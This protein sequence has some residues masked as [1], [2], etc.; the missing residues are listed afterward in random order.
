MCNNNNENS[1][2]FNKTFDPLNCSTLEQTECIYSWAHL[3]VFSPKY[4]NSSGNRASF[5]LNDFSYNS[6]GINHFNSIFESDSKPETIYNETLLND[7]NSLDGK[8][9]HPD[10]TSKK[11][12]NNKSNISTDFFSP[13]YITSPRWASET[14]LSIQS[15]KFS[16]PLT[17]SLDDFHYASYPTTSSVFKLDCLSDVTTKSIEASQQWNP[18]KICFF[19]KKK[20]KSKNMRVFFQ[21]IQYILFLL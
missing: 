10:Q 14:S 12:Y 5:N 11:L 16:V 20:I 15:L 8:P 9:I 18:G 19:F 6:C 17:K 13:K 3:D 2:N 1:V 21:S 4:D 7:N